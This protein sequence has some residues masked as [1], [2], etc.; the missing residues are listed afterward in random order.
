[1][2]Y[3]LPGAQI[4][5]I[6]LVRVS[7]EHQRELLE[8]QK[9]I[10]RKYMPFAYNENASNEIPSLGSDFSKSYGYAQEHHTLELYLRLWQAHS[11]DVMEN[12]TP[13]KCRRIIDLMFS[14][15]NKC[16]GNVDTVRKVLKKRRAECGPNSGSG[17]L[18]WFELFGYIFMT[19]FVSISMCALSM[20]WTTLVP[21]DSSKPRGKSLPTRHSSSR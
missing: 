10:A 4:K 2:V 8:F 15:W 9:Y 3:S 18:M 6:V 13:S 17:L 20:I 21:S 7:E 14:F 5:K 19:H 1:M 12:G 11:I 16:M